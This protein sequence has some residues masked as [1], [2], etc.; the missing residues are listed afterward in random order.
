MDSQEEEQD[1]THGLSR[2]NWRAN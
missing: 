2:Q 1:R